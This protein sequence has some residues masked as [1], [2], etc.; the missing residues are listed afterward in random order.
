MI[1]PE[2]TEDSI[3]RLRP[4]RKILNLNLDKFY[5][6]AVENMFQTVRSASNE[7]RFLI[8][9]LSHRLEFE[10]NGRCSG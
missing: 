4:L 2:L 3:P 9:Y 8:W 10:G 6:V 1:A 5:V 7:M